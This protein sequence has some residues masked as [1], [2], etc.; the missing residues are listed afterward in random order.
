MLLDQSE[1]AKG[2]AHGNPASPLPRLNQLGADVDP[3]SENGLRRPEPSPQALDIAR[4]HGEWRRGKK[5]GA[6]FPPAL[7]ERLRAH[8]IGS[9]EATANYTT[10]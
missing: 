7:G 1:E 3:M 6:Q 2:C 10:M 5:R 9:K 8:S 4:G